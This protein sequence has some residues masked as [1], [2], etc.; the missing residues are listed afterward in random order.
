MVEVVIEEEVDVEV[1]ELVEVVRCEEVVVVV[2]AVCQEKSV[3]SPMTKF[4]VP[5]LSYSSCA[6]R[7]RLCFGRR[8]LLGREFAS[9]VIELVWRTR[10]AANILVDRYG[11]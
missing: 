9:F 10:F 4:S 2:L 5:S 3:W 7:T 1:E 6:S 11:V 8:R